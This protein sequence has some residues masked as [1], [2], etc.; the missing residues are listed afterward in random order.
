MEW[1]EYRNQTLW[2]QGQTFF[3]VICCT[4][5]LVG[6]TNGFKHV[7]FVSQM[8][9]ETAE[10][11]KLRHIFGGQYLHII[12]NRTCKLSSFV[13]T[14]TGYVGISPLCHGFLPQTNGRFRLPI[15]TTELPLCLPWTPQ[16]NQQ[17][18]KSRYLRN[19]FFSST[20][21]KEVLVWERRNKTWEFLGNLFVL[22][23][24][25]FVFEIL[26]GTCFFSQPPGT[27]EGPDFWTRHD[28]TS[29]S[30]V[31]TSSDQ[32]DLCIPYLE[33][34]SSFQNIMYV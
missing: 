29:L 1:T 32:S 17:K 3:L 25:G 30:A 15:L 27:I 23:L 18:T 4:G 2:V 33:V 5:L 31:D 8:I 19:E 34:H 24:F 12:T 6:L 11:L 14:S 16:G 7:P 28:E 26:T 13:F 21:L 22:F 10:P 9:V 20:T